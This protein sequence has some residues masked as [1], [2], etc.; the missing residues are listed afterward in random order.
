ML[1]VEDTVVRY[2]IE[3][4]VWMPK[5]QNAGMV[6]SNACRVLANWERA[7]C[8]FRKSRGTEEMKFYL[9]ERSH[10]WDSLL[11]IEKN[12]NLVDG[13]L[14]STV[15]GKLRTWRMRSTRRQL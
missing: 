1:V 4:A 10:C 13:D 9:G 15:P 5:K 8:Y 2:K 14:M 3:G 6:H 11:Y 12:Q 7:F